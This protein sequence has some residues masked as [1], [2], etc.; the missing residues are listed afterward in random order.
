M[1]LLYASIC[2]TPQRIDNRE[3]DFVGLSI[4]MLRLCQ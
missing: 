3:S 4:L 2:L 1:G